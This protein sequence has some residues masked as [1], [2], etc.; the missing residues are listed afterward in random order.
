MDRLVRITKTVNDFGLLLKESEVSKFVKSDAPYFKSLYYYPEDVLDYFKL[1]NHS[2]KGYKGKVYTTE[3]TF[4]ID[5][6]DLEV[7]RDNTMRLL[8]YLEQQGLY[9]DRSGKLAFSGSK[10]FHVHIN[11]EHTFYP[12]ELKEFCLYITKQIKFNMSAGFKIDPTIYNTNRIF[13]VPNTP[14]EKTGLFKVEM[15]SNDLITFSMDQII[16]A[17]KVPQETYP[18]ESAI[19]ADAV[20]QVLA[21]LPKKSTLANIA[22]ETPTVIPSSDKPCI[23][24]LQSGDMKDGES[25]SGL[26]RL[27]N[28]YRQLGYSKEDTR[29]KLIE[30]AANREVK[31]PGTNTITLDKINQEILYSIFNGDGYTFT[32]SDWMLQDKCGG[33]C[34]RQC[35]VKPFAF[36]RPAPAKIEEVQTVEAPKQPETPV[37]R[38]SFRSA[39]PTLINTQKAHMT[40]FTS[41]QDTAKEFATFA[42]DS[43]KFRVETGIKEIDEKVRILPN[44]LTIVNARAGVGKSTLLLN[45]AADVSKKGQR[46]LVYQMDMASSEWYTKLSSKCLK[47]TPDEAIDLFFSEDP[48]L[49]GLKEEAQAKVAEAMSNI[50]MNYDSDLTAEKIEADVIELIKLDQKPSVIFI[51]YIQKMRGATDYGK[52]ADVLIKLKSIVAK[53]K[54]CIVALSQVPRGMGNEETPIFTAA[55]AQGGAIYEQNASI[56]INLWRPLKF[57]GSA[58]DTLMGFCVSKNRMGECFDGILHFKG[59]ISEMRDLAEQEKEDAAVSLAAYAAIKAEAQKKRGNFR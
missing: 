34:Q 29:V 28:H 25:N 46:G 3:I 18:Y 57:A 37:K 41:L 14:H 54:V 55:A 44:G 20:Q 38:A 9:D 40:S 42:K 12:K 24:A 45:M 35:A 22:Y 27:A 8:Q 16:E 11:T 56:C 1:N 47:I 4:D 10:G 52:A 26:L 31:H 21:H 36:N 7:S 32:C 51:D 48:E 50:L 5:S 58:E 17:A 23:V 30:A 59:S 6:K 19:S 39:V 43:K 49:E 53:Y 13:R 15:L 33:I 2:I